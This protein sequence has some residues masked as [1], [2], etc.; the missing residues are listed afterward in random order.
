MKLFI[1]VALLI[2]ATASARSGMRAED[3]LLSQVTPMESKVAIR[4]EV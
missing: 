4:G 3:A 2:I 1:L